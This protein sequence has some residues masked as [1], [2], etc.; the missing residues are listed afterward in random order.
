MEKNYKQKRVYTGNCRRDIRKNG[1][2]SAKIYGNSTCFA[3]VHRDEGAS[4]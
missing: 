2:K 4:C 1:F 3:F